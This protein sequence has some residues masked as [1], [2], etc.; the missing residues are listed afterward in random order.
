MLAYEKALEWQMLFDVAGQQQTAEEDMVATA[1]RIAG[2]HRKQRRHIAVSHALTEDLSSKKRYQDSA[3]V[4]L[5][6][7]KDP[8]EAVISLVQGGLFSEA[9]RIVGILLHIIVSC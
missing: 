5:D 9:R 6:Y 8:R 2:E 3:R 4:L 1:Y 7:A